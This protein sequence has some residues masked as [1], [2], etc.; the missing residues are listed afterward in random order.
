MPEPLH[1]ESM[2]AQISTGLAALDALEEQGPYGD[3]VSLQTAALTTALRATLV[4]A[5][6]TIGQC[7]KATPYGALRPVI[8]AAGAFHWCCTH[9]P[10]HC[11]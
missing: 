11:V 2:Q 9:D 6:G 7:R 4:A 8:D 3:T 1:W 10:E 5:Q